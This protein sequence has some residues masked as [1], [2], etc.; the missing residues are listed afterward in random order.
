MGSDNRSCGRVRAQNGNTR[1]LQRFSRRKCIPDLD[2]AVV[3]Q[4]NDVAS[5]GGLYQFALTALNDTASA[6]L[7]SLSIRT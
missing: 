3:V 2:R 1:K 5:Y 4:A 7:M 6:I